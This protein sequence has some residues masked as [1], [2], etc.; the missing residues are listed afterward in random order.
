MPESCISQDRGHFQAALG[1]QAAAH[2]GRT[3]NM[4]LLT[5]SQGTPMEETWKLQMKLTPPPVSSALRQT[6]G[7]K[8][9]SAPQV[10]NLQVTLHMPQLTSQ[11]SSKASSSELSPIFT[12]LPLKFRRLSKA[13]GHFRT[14]GF[15][16]RHRWG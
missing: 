10:L 7:V 8:V 11:S 16:E 5:N 2:R 3:S 1:H 4:T 15:S 14:A 9:P 12:Q 6:P 13:R